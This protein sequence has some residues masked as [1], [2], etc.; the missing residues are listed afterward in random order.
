MSELGSVGVMLRVGI[1]DGLVKSGSHGNMVGKIRRQ[2]SVEICGTRLKVS[3][4]ASV[5]HG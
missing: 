2:S 3:R 1:G 4:K 5:L